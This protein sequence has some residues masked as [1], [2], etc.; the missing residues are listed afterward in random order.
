[1]QTLKKQLTEQQAIALQKVHWE[2][3]MRRNRFIFLMVSHNEDQDDSW[4]QSDQY[5]Q[6]E[7]EYEDAYLEEML[8]KMGLM[9]ILLGGHVDGATCDYGESGIAKIMLPDEYTVTRVPEVDAYL[10]GEYDKKKD[11]PKED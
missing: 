4:M 5:E 11:A 8:F 7:A 1:M 6:M 10:A 9:D 2:A 3:T